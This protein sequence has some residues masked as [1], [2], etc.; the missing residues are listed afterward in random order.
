[1]LCFQESELYVSISGEH[2]RLGS[3]KGVSVLC[4]QDPLFLV[5]EPFLIMSLKSFA[6]YDQL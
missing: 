4:F 2:G 1:V 3:L 5:T 6:Y